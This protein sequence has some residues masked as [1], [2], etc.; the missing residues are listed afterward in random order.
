MATAIVSGR[1][2]VAVKER[3]G[4]YIHAA[5]LTAADVI[6]TV[7]E[8]IARTGELPTGAE[9]VAADEESLD[10][11]ERFMAFCNTLPDPNP[12]YAWLSQATPQELKDFLAEERLK[13]YE[14]L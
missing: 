5:G 10:P 12:E 11:F 8:R 1:V 7:W 2:D 13:D 14:R 4:A 3:A 9:E 6:K